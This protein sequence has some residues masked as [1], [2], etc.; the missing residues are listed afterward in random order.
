MAV[1][2]KHLTP[3]SKG[4]SI[5]VHKGKGASETVL[6]NRSVLNGLTGGDPAQRSQQQYAKATPMANPMADVPEEY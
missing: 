1:M 4:G 3:F 6:P 2:K 5:K